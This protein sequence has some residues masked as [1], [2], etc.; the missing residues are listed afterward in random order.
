MRGPADIF[1]TVL[2][3][4]LVIAALVAIPGAVARGVSAY[5]EAPAVIAGWSTPAQSHEGALFFA[6]DSDAPG[7]ARVAAALGLRLFLLIPIVAYAAAVPAFA[8]D[9]RMPYAVM[10]AVQVVILSVA[11]LGLV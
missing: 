6:Q 4:T 2:R 1:A 8:R 9:R 10:A 3:W 7:A 5:D 11:A